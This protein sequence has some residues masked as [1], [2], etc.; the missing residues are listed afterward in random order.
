MNNKFDLLLVGGIVVTGQGAVRADVGVR[1]G[2]VEAVEPDLSGDPAERTV[3]VS[4][5]LLLPGVIDVHVHPV[6]L[7]NM[8]QCSTEDIQ[9]TRGALA[10]VGPPI[11]T[12]EDQQALWLALRDNTLQVISSDHAPKPKDPD[13]PFLEQGFGSPQLETV[14]PLSYDQGWIGLPRLV[15]LLS[16]NPARIF[17]L[18]MRKGTIEVGSDADIVVFDP[19]HRY[20]ITAANQHS[21]VGYT[22]MTGGPYWAGP[23]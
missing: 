3:D 2:R 21:N 11:R 4:G 14:P 15:Q 23:R 22:C 8:E 6:Y 5:R 20:T 18:Y 7:D 13:G 12:A 17:G 10:K 16:E 1:Q 9:A 19:S